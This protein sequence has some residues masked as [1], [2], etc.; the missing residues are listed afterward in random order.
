MQKIISLINLIKKYPYRTLSGVL[1]LIVVIILIVT[2]AGGDDPVV[3]AEAQARS[4]EVITVSEFATGA[5]GSFAPTAS[6]NSFVVRAQSGGRVDSTSEE[7]R[8]VNQGDVL[9]ALENS[10]ER[11]S[12]TQAEGSYEAAVAGSASS[13][14][15]L[16]ETKTSLSAAKQSAVEAD[17]AALTAYNDVLFNTVDQLFT[18][19]RLGNPGV[20][21]NAQGKANSLGNDRVSMNET[22]RNW[23]DQSESLSSTMDNGALVSVLDE[24][25]A[26]IDRLSV[27]VDTFIVLL[28]KQSSDGIFSDSEI[29]TMQTEFATAKS[30]LN[31][32]R[33]TLQTTKTSLVQAEEA[34]NSATV[35]ASGAEISSADAAVKQALGILQAARSVYEKTIVRAPFSGVVTS[36]NVMVGDIITSGT[37]I[38]IIVP[39]NDANTESSFQLPL[40]AVKYTPAGAYV[41][42]PDEA[43][44]LTTIEV[45]TGLVT[46]SNITVTGLI[47][48]EII[49]KDV[50]GLNQG[51]KVIID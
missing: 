6:G 8:S 27:M 22:L 4:V 48:D 9:A 47:G 28:P 14:I 50:R 41:L 26:N 10:S 2:A 20:R 45:E 42:S 3:E 46:T 36:L 11:A 49:I 31:T 19:P 37:D 16:T 43:E 25:I 15:D 23:Q 34:V 32:Q 51:D 35:A 24:A 17:R 30:T 33:S 29:S 1:A 40:S 38:A 39:D 12:L 21:I 18:N 7:G 13:D 44:T 5:V